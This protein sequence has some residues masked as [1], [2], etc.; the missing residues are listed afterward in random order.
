M[1]CPSCGAD[2]K[3]LTTMLQDD[4]RDKYGNRVLAEIIIENCRCCA[5]YFQEKGAL[6]CS[7]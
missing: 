2:R 7:S 4:P 5:K 1:L 6:I 3:Q